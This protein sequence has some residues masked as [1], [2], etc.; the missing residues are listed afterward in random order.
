MTKAELIEALS[1]YSDSMQVVIQLKELGGEG[2]EFNT[3]Y[4]VDY[5][6]YE[7]E[8]DTLFLIVEA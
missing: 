5:D 1:G 3:Y 6:D 8:T 7:S 4:D 2:Q